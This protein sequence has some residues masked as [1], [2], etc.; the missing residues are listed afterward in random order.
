MIRGTT[1][2]HTFDIGDE[3]FDTSTLVKVNILYGQDDELLFRKK[4]AACTIDGRTISTKL[5]RQESLLFS[6]EKLAQVQIVAEDVS[7][8][9][10]ETDVMTFAVGKLLDDGVLE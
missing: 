2:T 1:P 3:S 8:E 6:H 5:T 10:F 4:H 7:G 9:T